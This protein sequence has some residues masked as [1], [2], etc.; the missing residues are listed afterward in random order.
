MVCFDDIRFAG[1][2][3]T[4]NA[5]SRILYLLGLHPDAQSKLRE[6]LIEAGAPDNLDYDL[7]DRL[8]YLEA[9]C[10]ET[11]RLHAPVRF[12]QRVYVEY[13]QPAILY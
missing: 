13:L 11:L 4:S 6:E 9:V 3:T 5:L 1:T 8:P 10:R 7:L 12:L 2:D